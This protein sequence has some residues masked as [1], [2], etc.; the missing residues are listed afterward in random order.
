MSIQVGFF[1]YPT[2]LL[3]LSKFLRHTEKSNCSILNHYQTIHYRDVCVLQRNPSNLLILLL[4]LSTLQF[5]PSF[6][7]LLRSRLSVWSLPRGVLTRRSNHS[8]YQEYCQILCDLHAQATLK[9]FFSWNTSKLYT[10]WN[11]S[12]PH[13]F[14]GKKKKKKISELNYSTSCFKCIKELLFSCLTAY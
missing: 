10:S 6:T 1:S 8:S 5:L 2:F 3:S 4:R 9:A 7:S 12:G 14:L 11:G 13:R